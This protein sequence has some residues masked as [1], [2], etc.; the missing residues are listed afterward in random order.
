MPKVRIIRLFQSNVNALRRANEMLKISCKMNGGQVIL[1]ETNQAILREAV[2]K[3]EE[4][5]A[6]LNQIEGHL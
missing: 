2:K 1:G 6:L 3:I 5:E 4:A